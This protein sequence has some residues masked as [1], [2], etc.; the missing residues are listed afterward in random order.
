[1]KMMTNRELSRKLYEYDSPSNRLPAA[2]REV[3]LLA[4]VAF[5]DDCN[6]QLS[7]V[8]INGDRLSSAW[9]SMEDEARELYK[10]IGYALRWYWMARDE[11]D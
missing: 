5:D 9:L 3:V 8:L 7:E 1:M 2:I 6:K 4:S 10:N 11:V